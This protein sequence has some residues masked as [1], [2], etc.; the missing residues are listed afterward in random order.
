VRRAVLVLVLCVAGPAC[1]TGDD[2]GDR[3]LL[4]LRPVL[5]A[6]PPPCPDEKPKGDEVVV[7]PLTADGK[8]ECLEL[9][10][11]I[12]DAKDVRSATVA[13]TTDGGGTCE[14][15]SS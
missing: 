1:G 14:R 2:S 8:V 5:A 4:E 3:R 11:A 12:V 10:R 15:H 6:T 7:L 9:G 13:E